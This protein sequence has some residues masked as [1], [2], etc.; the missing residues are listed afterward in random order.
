[1]SKYEIEEIIKEE[2]WRKVLIDLVIKN[3]LNPWDLDL[4]VLIE[5]LKEK[6]QSGDLKLTSDLILAYAI[7]LKFKSLLIDLEEHYEVNYDK[8][9]FKRPARKLRVTLKQLIKVIKKY[10][11]K[12]RNRVITKQNNVE[13]MPEVTLDTE[14]F[15]EPEDFKTKLEEFLNMIDEKKL[16]SELPGNRLMN[17]YYILI[18]SNE[19]KISFNQSKPFDDIEVI[20]NGE[21]N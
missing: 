20:R 11:K 8:V 2:N 10:I 5:K 14:I 19:G 16:L 21:N 13:H 15:I 3:S 18:L 1:M 7:I 6:I 9:N 17:F 4:N 12:S